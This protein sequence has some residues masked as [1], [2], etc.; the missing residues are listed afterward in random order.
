MYS[1]YHEDE[2]Y[3]PLL[4]ECASKRLIEIGAWA[5]IC[6]SNSRALIEIGWSALLIE[7]SPGPVK[8]QAMEYSHMERV[9]ILAAAVTVEGGYLD[10]E[11]TDDAVSQITGP[12]IDEWRTTGGFYGRLTVPAIKAADLFER[13]GA[14]VEFVS[15]DVEGSSVDLFKAM[16]DLG[17]RPRVVVL[18]HDSR[19][20]E[21]AQIAESANYQQIHLN[22]TNVI[23]RW[24]GERE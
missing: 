24:T 12:R 23:L 9:Q 10:L 4:K 3:V 15:I 17:P 16:C 2:I 14:G 19:Y 7:P 13:F 5:P 1:Q 20:V 8:A 11:I 21:V 18:E 22:G 6:F